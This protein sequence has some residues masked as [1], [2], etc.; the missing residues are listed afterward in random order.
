MVELRVLG[1]LQLTAPDR[2]EAGSL[3]H[4]AKRAALLAYLAAA[5]PRGAH[6]RDKLLALFWPELDQARAR[7]ALNQTVYVLREA[8]GEDALGPRGDGALGVTDVVW[9]DATAFEAA[10]EAGNPAEALAL[11]RGDLLEGFFISEAPDVMNAD[12]SGQVRLTSDAA[13]DHGPAWSPNGARIAFASRRDGT[14]EIYVMNADGSNVLRLSATGENSGPAWSP[15]G[16]QIA[17]HHG[18][19]Y[20]SCDYDLFRMNAGG[21]GILQLTSGDPPADTDPA[22]SRDGQWIAFAT[23]SCDYYQ[24][25]YYSAIAAVKPDGSGRTEILSGPV[26]QPVWRP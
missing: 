12:G 16:L 17:F 20:Y 14:D 6:R 25:C 24:G 9:C 8:L 4:Q 7:A 19:C 15:D 1:T 21:S 13:A 26:F 11:Y 22:W 18:Q 2:R 23:V 5:A 10:L 3:V